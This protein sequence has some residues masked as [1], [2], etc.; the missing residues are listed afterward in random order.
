MRVVNRHEG[1]TMYKLVITTLLLT[2]SS[3]NY[4]DCNKSLTRT[5]PD[6]RYELLNNN[7][8]VKDKET[9]LIWQR[10]SLGQTWS[11]TS[12]TGKTTEYEW[13]AALQAAKKMGSG[14]RMPNVTELSSLLELACYFPAINK[15]FFPDTIHGMFWSSSPNAYRSN[16][17]W[18][19]SF[20][21]GGV[22]S[23]ESEYSN[24]T[25][26]QEGGFCRYV[27]LVRSGK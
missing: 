19:V 8:E 26:Y 6:N 4:A 27:R 13:K 11:G 24:Q 2:V 18:C 25:G 20:Y 15:D 16:H 22:I 9:G 23:N 21:N 12:C 17:V 14:W 3:T 1:N 10:C 5:A 7:T